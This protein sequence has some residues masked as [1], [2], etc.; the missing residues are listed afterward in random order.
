MYVPQC[1]CEGQLAG[2]AHSS[3]RVRPRKRTLVI[4]LG[5]KPL[6]AKLSHWPTLGF[7]AFGFFLFSL[8]CVV[9]CS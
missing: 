3:H 5:G 7:V 9:L 8:T 1:T 6:C 4:R 2:V